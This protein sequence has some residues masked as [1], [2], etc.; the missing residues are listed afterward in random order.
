M[1]VHPCVLVDLE[2]SVSSAMKS[3]MRVRAS[4]SWSRGFVVQ[5]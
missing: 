2:V 1:V 4:A 3:W 5:G